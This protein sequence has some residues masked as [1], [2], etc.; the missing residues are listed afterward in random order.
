MFETLS[1]P[2]HTPCSSLSSFY[3]PPLAPHPPLN[4]GAEGISSDKLLGSAQ[5][6]ASREQILI[7]FGLEETDLPCVKARGEVSVRPSAPHEGVGLG[8]IRFRLVNMD[9]SGIRPVPNNNSILPY[10]LW[11]QRGLQ[12]DRSFSGPSAEF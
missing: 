5:G 1:V 9:C 2:N 7:S 10:M 8:C 12:Q 11:R 4:P 6:L 3:P